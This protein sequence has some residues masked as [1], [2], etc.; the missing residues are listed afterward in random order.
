M[1]T[2]LGRDP[3]ERIARL[4]PKAAARGSKGPKV[5][6]IDCKQFYFHQMAGL[7]PP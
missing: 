4:E 5:D 7:L 3:F 1:K 6:D 2:W